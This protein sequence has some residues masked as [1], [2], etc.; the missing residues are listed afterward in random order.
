MA[1]AVY[2]APTDRSTSLSGCGVVDMK[3][4]VAEP[5]ITRGILIMVLRR[6]TSRCWAGMEE[7]SAAEDGVSDAEEGAWRS[8]VRCVRPRCFSSL[9]V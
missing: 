9:R 7:A 8:A 2:E 5:R 6:R 3:L 4:P 1:R